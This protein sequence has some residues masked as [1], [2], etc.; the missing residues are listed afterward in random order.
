MEFVRL[1]AHARLR[2]KRHFWMD[3]PLDYLDWLT[4]LGV[5]SWTA[6]LELTLF[7][8]LLAFATSGAS[9]VEAIAA[10]TYKISTVMLKKSLKL[11]T[12][13]IGCIEVCM[14]D[15]IPLHIQF[16]CCGGFFR[17]TPPELAKINNKFPHDFNCFQCAH[18]IN[19][20]NIKIDI[21]YIFPLKMSNFGR[22]FMCFLC[23]WYYNL[24][25]FFLFDYLHVVHQSLATTIQFSGIFGEF[26]KFSRK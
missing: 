15:S 4:H 16:T 1:K 9:F 12:V 18:L 25:L 19:P 23:V 5:G 20:A 17:S 21:S 6:Q 14:L 7:T 26:C 3:F 8:Q 11:S 22:I 24:F 13:S 2:I 10:D